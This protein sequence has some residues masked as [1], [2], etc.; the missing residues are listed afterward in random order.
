MQCGGAGCEFSLASRCSSVKVGPRGEPCAKGIELKRAVDL[1]VSSMLLFLL[2]P[3]F[4]ILAAAIKATSRGPVLFRQVR[5]GR[6]GRVF[7]ILKFRTM[8]DRAEANGRA[9]TVGGDRRVTAVGRLLRRTKLDEL[10]QLVNVLRGEMSLVGPRPEVPE[11]VEMFWEAFEPILA[12]RPG[13]THRA[14][15]LYR[16]EEAMLARAEDPERCYREEVLPCKLRLYTEDLDRS[17]VLNDVRVLCNTVLSVAG[18]AAEAESHPRPATLSVR[19]RFP[20]PVEKRVAR[21]PE[22]VR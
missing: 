21:Q 10:P 7:R 5:V 18:L 12:I 17:G 1:V 22:L 19:P 2:F 11:Y 8:V 14:S 15:V 16:D 20:R 13:I 3:L 9:I 6:Y 4:I